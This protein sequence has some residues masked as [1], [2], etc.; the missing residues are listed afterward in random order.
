MELDEH[1]DTEI[2]KSLSFISMSEPLTQRSDSM[3]ESAGSDHD[4]S[5]VD[6]DFHDPEELLGPLLTLCTVAGLHIRAPD[7]TQ[8]SYL[9]MFQYVLLF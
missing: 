7:S 9:R 1:V 4:D 8:T 5:T 2:A 3:F 6:Q